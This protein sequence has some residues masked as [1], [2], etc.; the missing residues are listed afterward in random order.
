MSDPSNTL[1]RKLRKVTPAGFQGRT[2]SCEVSIRL[3]RRP[4]SRSGRAAT[5]TQAAPGA[6]LVCPAKALT[7]PTALH[8]DCMH[9]S[10]LCFAELGG[11]YFHVSKARNERLALTLRHGRSESRRERADVQGRWGDPWGA[12]GD[13]LRSS[14]GVKARTKQLG[15][16]TRHFEATAVP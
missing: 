1:N 7:G 2:M 6:G 9:P 13:R 12:R 10:Q 16:T 8:C 11:W 3:L 4:G 14:A 5:G 15:K